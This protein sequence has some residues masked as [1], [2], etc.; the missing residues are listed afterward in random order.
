MSI[1][2]WWAEIPLVLRV[3]YVVSVPAFVLFAIGV[4]TQSNNRLWF[5]WFPLMF[6]LMGGLLLLNVSGS[7][8]GMS[9]QMRRQRLMGID[10]SKS[11]LAGPGYARFM[12]GFMVVIGGAMTWAILTQPMSEL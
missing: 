5:V 11:W 9:R 3:A 12:G 4:L 10:F 8:A 1:T 6:L 7:A 2:R